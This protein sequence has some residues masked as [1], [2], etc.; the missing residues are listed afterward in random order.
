MTATAHGLSVGDSFT[1]SGFDTT[2]I[3]NYSHVV[4]TV[5]DANTFTFTITEAFLSATG[6]T[7]TLHKNIRIFPAAS[8]QLALDSYAKQS[9]GGYKKVLYLI[10]LGESTSKD[11]NVGS[12][13]SFEMMRST[14]FKM[15]F[16][17]RFGCL[18]ILPIK[19]DTI[20]ANAA[21]FARDLQKYFMRSLVGYQLPADWENSKSSAI[22]LVSS[23]RETSNNAY[24]SQNYTFEV[25]EYVGVMDVGR[26]DFGYNIVDFN[27]RVIPKIGE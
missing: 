11:R 12:D 26:Y 13:A 7:G 22:T 24:I 10:D 18:A 19:N 23:S 4:A 27:L 16:V 8:V 2:E 14:D 21:D 20:G 1:L 6:V 15:T 3:I 25:S 9:D 17:N 5:T